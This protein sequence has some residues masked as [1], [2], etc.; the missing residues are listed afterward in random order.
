MADNIGVL[1]SSAS[2][3]AATA[4][5]YTCPANKAAKFRLFAYMQATA[6]PSTVT[7][8]CNGIG[9]AAVAIGASQVIFTNGGAGLFRAA[10]AAAGTGVSAAETA[11][12][13]PP[14]YY[15]SAG[16]TVTYTPSVALL[17]A[18]VQ[19]VGVEIDLSP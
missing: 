2:I 3:A 19:V 16:Q 14:I 6:T 17:F 5:A 11:Q 12:P 10:G 18:S 15:L 1:G 7:F 4:T 9:L 13:A 8:A